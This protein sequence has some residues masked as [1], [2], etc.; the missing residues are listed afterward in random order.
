MCGPLNLLGF[1]FTNPQAAIKRHPEKGG[2]LKRLSLLREK[3]LMPSSANYGNLLHFM[4]PLGIL[5]SRIGS[6]IL[7]TD[8]NTGINL[9]SLLIIRKGEEDIDGVE[10]DNSRKD[11]AAYA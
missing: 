11:L 9:S 2:D 6:S 4:G 8:V 1:V 5:E 3:K 7:L 10:C